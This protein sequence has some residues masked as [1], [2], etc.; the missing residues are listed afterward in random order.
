MVAVIRLP[1]GPHPHSHGENGMFTP[2]VYSFAGSSPLTRGKLD[3]QSDQRNAHGLIPAHAGKTLRALARVKQLRA[4]P[5]SHGENVWAPLQGRRGKTSSPLT[6][7]KLP[8]VRA[9]TAQVRLIPAHAGKTFRLPFR[10]VRG[11]AHPCSRGENH[12]LKGK[13]ET[14]GASSPLTRGKPWGRVPHHCP[15]RLIPAHA[16]K[17]GFRRWCRR[18]SGA[19]PRSRGENQGFYQCVTPEEGSSPLTRGKRN[20]PCEQHSLIG[21]IPAHT[22][23]T[24]LIASARSLCGAHPRSRGENEALAASDATDKGSSPLTRG[25]HVDGELRTDVRGLIPAHAGKTITHPSGMVCSAAHPRSRGEN[26]V[27]A[28]QPRRGP[29]SSPLTRGKRSC[30]LLEALGIGLIPAHAGKTSVSLRS[31]PSAAAHPRSRGEN[32]RRS[33]PTSCARGSSPLTRG[34]RTPA[35]RGRARPG[36][37]PAHAGKTCRKAPGSPRARAHPRSRGENLGV[38]VRRRWCRGSSPLTR[39]KLGAGLWAGY[40]VGLIPAHAGKT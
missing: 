31:R 16:G 23:K 32:C 38:G 11:R 17:T 34:K 3:P 25:K 35:T 2:P 30:D 29:G 37:I 19:H 20:P 7:G 15:R 4:H 26:I 14:M 24:R 9:R 1:V 13:T 18:T 10:R 8:S 21:L 27:S 5:R 33:I 6:R 40:T 12:W 39:G 36:L 22:G 28:D